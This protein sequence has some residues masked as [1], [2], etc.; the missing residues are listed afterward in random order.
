[1]TTAH[2]TVHDSAAEVLTTRRLVAAG[3]PLPVTE[4]V[5]CP[6]PGQGE[7]RIRARW[8]LVSPGTELH[9]LDRSARTGERFTLG[10]CSVG[11]V[12]TVGTDVPGFATG[13]LVIAMGWGEAVHAGVV[14]VP[15]RLC[16]RVP[17]GV[18]AA[19]AVVANLGATAVHAVD[20][21]GLKPDDE[22][23]VVGAGMVGQLVAQTVAA[24]GNRVTLLDLRP[25]RLHAA[26]ELGLAV[27]EGPSFLART[28][29]A[30][31]RGGR[32]VLLCGTGDADDTVAAAA[33]WTSRAPG[34]PRLVGVGRF[35]ARIDF[36]VELGNL[37]IR[38]AARCGAGYRDASYARGLSEV[39][40][41]AGEYTVTE[42]LQR[43]LDLI[44]SGQIC[45]AA[46]R[47][48]RVPFDEATDA[49]AE[50][51]TRPAHPTTLLA[52]GGTPCDAPKEQPAP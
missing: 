37:D 30:A 39:T 21:A 26:A 13:D 28:Q 38:Y 11:T 9:Y 16:R 15:Y 40:P 32:C 18:D 3:S 17:Q 12:E 48:P 6:P 42:N 34:R 47:L 50:L 41:P 29:A 45:P 33:R 7:L 35:S 5:A 8:S 20:R 1:M 4:E 43:A 14:T 36:S 24:R 25:D 27:A 46:M 23:A 19:D 2:D 22:V 10:Y 44:V 51:R 31:G 52:H 49:Y